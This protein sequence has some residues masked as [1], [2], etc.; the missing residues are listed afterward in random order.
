MCLGEKAKGMTK[1]LFAVILEGLLD[2]GQYFS[3]TEGCLKSV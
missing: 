1:Q 2:K 3:H